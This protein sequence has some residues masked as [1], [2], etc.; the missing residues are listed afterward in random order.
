MPVRV[1]EI[2]NLQGQAINAPGMSANAAGAPGQALGSLARSIAGV[3]D[4]FAEK[5]HQIQDSENVRIISET[6][7]RISEEYALF[8]VENQKDPDPENRINNTLKFLQ[9]QKGSIDGADYSPY[10]KDSLTQHFDTFANRARISS[11]EDAANL[12]VRR[13]SLALDNE[14]TN[15]KN[16]LDLPAFEAGLENARNAGVVLPEQEDALRMD[17]DRNVEF[18]SHRLLAEDNPRQLLE[19]LDA[20]NFASDNPNLT[21]DDIDKLKRYGKQQI[22][23]KRGEEIDTFEEALY[24]GKLG[25]GDIDSAEFL[26]AKDRA[27]FTSSLKRMAEEKPISQEDYLNAWKFTDVLRKA[28]QDPRVTDDQYR[29][30]HN[31]VRTDLLNSIPPSQQGDIKKELGYLSPAGRDTSSGG[32]KPNV[33]DLKAIARSQISRAAD[34][35]LYGDMSEEAPFQSRENAARR[36]EDMR[37]RANQFIESKSPPPSPQEVRDYVDSLNGEAID[38]SA[39]LI[40]IIP[41]SFSIPEA[42]LDLLLQDPNSATDSLL[43]PKP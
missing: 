30:L 18:Q 17:F 19:D 11:I 37:L 35:N 34:A 9:S 12:T 40:P 10:V 15:A 27:A 2:P 21:P 32:S 36:A 39:N 29:A 8:Q 1:T 41:P 7:N 20:E 31:E 5:A 26:S 16:N 33:T 13:A 28:R 24:Q 4:A 25:Q 22:E 6:R 14:L 38:P 23:F 42:D 43:G 3:S